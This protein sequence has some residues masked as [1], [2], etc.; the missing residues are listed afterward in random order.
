MRSLRRSSR[1]WTTSS[2][3]RRRRRRRRWREPSKRTRFKEEGSR[4]GLVGGRLWGGARVRS[5]RAGCTATR[6]SRADRY[7]ATGKCM[8]A[9]WQHR[10]AAKWL[11]SL[12]FRAWGMVAW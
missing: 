5:S 2:R 8:R 10:S 3:R 12:D 4:G 11:D 7:A 6:L 1:W 9:T